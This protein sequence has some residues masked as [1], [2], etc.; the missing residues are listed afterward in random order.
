M[1]DV[2]LIGLGPK[3]GS[4]L[5]SL[6]AKVTVVG[7][8]READT[9]AQFVDRVVCRA[10]GA[11]IPI[12]SDISTAA[13]ENLVEHFNPDC[14]V[15]SSYNRILKPPPIERCPF[16]NVHYAPLPQYRGR[17]N[18]NWALINDEPSAGITIHT[19]VPGLDAG[20]ILFQRIIPIQD[21]HT[22]A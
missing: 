10:Q 22:V 21:G 19:I 20:N 11:G 7:L 17:A 16:I 13:I 6:I 5:D 1:A 3:A 14:V 18:V 15:V 8:L 9:G 12:Y 2:L 4:A